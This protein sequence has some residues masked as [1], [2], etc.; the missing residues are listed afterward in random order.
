MLTVQP[1][2]VQLRKDGS[3]CSQVQGSLAGMTAF[4]HIPLNKVQ[5]WIRPGETLFETLFSISIHE[6]FESNV[7]KMLD[8]T[9]P[10]PDVS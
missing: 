2:R 8:S 7:W 1:L 9:Q 4:E 5:Q 3:L 6:E 10:Q